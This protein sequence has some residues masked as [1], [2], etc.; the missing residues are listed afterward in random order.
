MPRTSPALT[1]AALTGALPATRRS[2]APDLARGLML[3]IIAT[4]HAHQFRIT[5]G[6]GYALA[7]PLDVA[8]T[9]VMALVAENRGYPMFAALFGYGLARMYH[10]RETAGIQ[11]PEI[12]SLLRRRGWC[13]VLIGLGHTALLFFGDVIAVYGVIAIVYIAAVRF[14][15]RKLLTHALV[16]MV[17]GS[18]VYTVLSAMFFSSASSGEPITDPLTDAIVRVAILPVFVPLLITISVFP[19]L[20]GIWAARRRLLENTGEHLALLRKVACWGIG[21]G[22]VGGVPAALIDVEVWQPGQTADLGVSWL[23]LLTGYAGG[24]GYAAAIALISR[25]IGERSGRPAGP[26]VTA[27]AA[28]GQRSM[29]SYLLQS[30]AWAILVPPYAL[31]LGSSLTDAQAVGI[32]IGVWLVTVLLAELQRRAGFRQGPAEWLLRRMTYGSRT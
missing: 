1:G 9:A 4:V 27:L 23:H 11:W 28:T 7:G 14:G 20:I 19:F 16:W 22:V 5:T 13:L 30:L 6:E 2:L 3:L 10:R 12:R 26:V 15:D 25:R 21:L 32:G 17:L 18:L 24:F 31:G 8:V 29:T